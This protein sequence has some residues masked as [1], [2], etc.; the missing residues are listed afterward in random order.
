[1]EAKIIITMNLNDNTIKLRPFRLQGVPFCRQD[2]R[3]M[4]LIRKNYEEKKLTTA[5]AIYQTFTEL[6]SIAGRGKGRHTNQFP[7]YYE[8]IAH[9]S[10]KSVSTIKRYSKDF[11]E[12][13][14]LDWETRKKGKMNLA[15]L[16]KLLDYSGQNS[17]PTSKQNNDTNPVG[18]NNEP[19]K[20]EFI[21]KFI[22]NK[23]RNKNN[24]NNGEW[25]RVRD[26]FER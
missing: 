10:G 25:T 22:N 5:K 16:W 7:A 3:I 8:T 12:L 24:I 20:E 26:M 17:G 21:R 2:V 4:T 15:N 19:L 13:K 1:L 6:A 11:R 9:W 18:Q 14:I 23:G